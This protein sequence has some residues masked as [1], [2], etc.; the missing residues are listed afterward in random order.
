M[1]YTGGGSRL[2]GSHGSGALRPRHRPTTRSVKGQVIIRER[3]SLDPL[4]DASERNRHMLE[5]EKDLNGRV[6]VHGETL[7]CR[8]FPYDERSKIRDVNLPV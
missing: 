7:I 8:K 6:R 3:D 2:P 5:N 4:Q 1:S